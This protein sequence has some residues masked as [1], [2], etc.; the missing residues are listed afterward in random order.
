MACNNYFHLQHMEFSVD[1]GETQIHDEIRD[2]V[3]MTLVLVQREI[4]AVMEHK[5]E[6]LERAQ[7][8]IIECVAFLF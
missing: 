2:E 4:A 5:L 7:E 6:L 1:N 8:L 3:M